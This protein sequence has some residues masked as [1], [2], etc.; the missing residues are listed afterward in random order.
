MTVF[1]VDEARET[2]VVV[3]TLGTTEPVI[4]QAEQPVVHIV[5][6]DDFPQK[7]KRK[8]KSGF[9]CG[10][11]IALFVLVMCVVPILFFT[12]LGGI[13]ATWER[14]TADTV[15]GTVKEGPDGKFIKGYGNDGLQY[16]HIAI[17]R[18]DTGQTEVLQIRDSL[19]YNQFKSADLYQALEPGKTYEFKVFGKRIDWASQ[20]RVI[21]EFKL[22]QSAANSNV[23]GSVITGPQLEP[24]DNR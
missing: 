6:P 16:Y 11:L 5:V 12:F 15:I 3:N 19:T 7:P 24:S 1:K 9:P 8:G 14:T 21:Y 18:K 2:P 10:C 17:V 23:G 22:L 4:E 13:N 20:F